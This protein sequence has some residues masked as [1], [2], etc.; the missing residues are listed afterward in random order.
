MHNEIKTEKK[1]DRE[2]QEV[3]GGSYDEMG[4]YFTPDGSNYKLN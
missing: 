3:I 4:F 1:A 2:F